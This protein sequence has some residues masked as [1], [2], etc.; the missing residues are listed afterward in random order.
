MWADEGDAREDGLFN[1]E[2]MNLAYFYGPPGVVAP[3]FFFSKW[4][5]NSIR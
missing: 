2:K 4:D 5:D 3:I 1:A